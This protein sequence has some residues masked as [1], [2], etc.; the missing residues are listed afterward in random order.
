MKGLCWELIK[1]RW[2]FAVLSA[3]KGGARYALQLK[4][5]AQLF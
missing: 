4:I 1:S 3:S 2:G 5:L